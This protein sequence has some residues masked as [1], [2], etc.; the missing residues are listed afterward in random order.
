MPDSYRLNDVEGRR[1]LLA[2][3]IDADGHFNARTNLYTVVQGTAWYMRL[4]R[5][6]AFVVRYLGFSCTIMYTGTDGRTSHGVPIV[7]RFASV[8]LRFM[9]GDAVSFLLPRKH[10][11]PKKKADKRTIIIKPLPMVPD[12]SACVGFQLSGD[13]LFLRNDFVVLSAPFR[14]PRD[15]N[16]MLHAFARVHGEGLHHVHARRRAM[17]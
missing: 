4:I 3:M 14:H 15:D 9:G 5:H 1:Q 17:E 8:R 7:E 16:C 6:M 2:G 10:G 13:G 12:P 11:H